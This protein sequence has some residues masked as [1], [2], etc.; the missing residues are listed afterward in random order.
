MKYD[1]T[2]EDLDEDEII[3]M[4]QYSCLCYCNECCGCNYDSNYNNKSYAK[5][6]YNFRK[7]VKYHKQLLANQ[8]FKKRLHGCRD[9][10]FKL[11][12]LLNEYDEHN[13]FINHV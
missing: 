12:K 13:I 3:A 6:Y 7:C 2:I 4:C 11:L 9:K 10:Y 8:F 1:I 5:T